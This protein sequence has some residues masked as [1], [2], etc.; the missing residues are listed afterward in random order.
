MA[1][2]LTMNIVAGRAPIPERFALIKDRFRKSE[3]APRRRAP[4]D[5][6]RK[7]MSNEKKEKSKKSASSEVEFPVGD[8]TIRFTLEDSPDPLVK[9]GVLH[10]EDL[11]EK[12]NNIKFDDNPHYTHIRNTTFQVNVLSFTDDGHIYFHIPEAAEEYNPNN[13]TFPE[14]RFNFWGVY[15][16]DD[17]SNDMEL[18]GTGKV[19]LGFY[20][21][22]EL[23]AADGDNV[24]WT[25]KGITDPPHK[26]S[27]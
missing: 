2:C 11:G 22:T 8:W 17:V 4:R 21:V 14:Y 27:K 15:A 7:T 3:H 9:M 26:H 13:P 10:L 6:K 1:A 12:G 24:V 5:L 25:S 23:P 18:N 19:P 20:P 16:K